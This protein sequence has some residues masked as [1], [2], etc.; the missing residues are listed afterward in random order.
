MIGCT[1]IAR[2]G[3]WPQ[4]LL[5]APAI[6]GTLWATW[7]AKPL[8]P[9]GVIASGFMVTFLGDFQSRPTE[10][11]IMTRVNL[12]GLT[13]RGNVPDTPQR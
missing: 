8:I 5:R 7:Q 3:L 10:I 4:S 12:D 1:R 9:N 13:L 11:T 2:L 6:F